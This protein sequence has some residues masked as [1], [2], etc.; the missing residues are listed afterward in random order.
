MPTTA[1]T[2]FAPAKGLFIS[3][4]DRSE[5]L[6]YTSAHRGS[7]DRPDGELD[8]SACLALLE[9][10]FVDGNG[11]ADGVGFTVAGRSLSVG[12]VVTLDAG[13][14]WICDAIGW[15]Q[16]PEKEAQ[17][18]PPDAET[19]PPRSFDLDR[20][21]ELYHPAY[22]LPVGLLVYVRR[23]EIGPDLPLPTEVAVAGRCKLS[24]D[25]FALENVPLHGL[26]AWI[27][28]TAIQIALPDL[29]PGEREWI[30]SG[31]RPGAFTPSG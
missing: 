25:F 23:S 3:Y 5:Y 6:T 20:F 28:G 18:F 7:T 2:V 8:E 30:K 29:A 27:A 31:I 16:L 9:S 11:M 22:P 26:G 21:T 14:T 15:R 24:G 13:G 10:L 4:L 17:R 1:F 19:C 12:D